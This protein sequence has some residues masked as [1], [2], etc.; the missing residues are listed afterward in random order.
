MTTKVSLA[1]EKRTLSKNSARDIRDERRVPGVVYG[2]GFDNVLVSVD[3]SDVLR[4]HRKTEDGEV[5]TLELGG[6]KHNVVFQEIVV[7]PVKHEISH[8]D[9]MI[10]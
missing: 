1:A 4:A 9:F 7:H 2:K 10:A 3:A 8:V 5:F 6:K